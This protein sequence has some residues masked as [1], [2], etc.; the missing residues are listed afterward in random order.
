MNQPLRVLMV[1]DSEDDATLS[2]LT[3]RRGG[4]EVVYAAVDTPAA[5][6]DAL[7]HQDW[8]VITSDH[9]I[10]H[11]SAPAALALAKELCPDVPFIIVSGQ[12]D[13]NLAV[14]LIKEGAQDYIQ[15]RELPRLVPTIE[16]E[17]REAKMRREHQQAKDALEISE[18]RYR[19]L[20]ETAR[21]GI[22]ILDADSGQI[23][24]VNPF[25]I[26]MLG[27]SKEDL[28]GKKLWEIGAIRDKEASR[29]AFGELQSKGYVR[30]EDLPLETIAGQPVSVEFVS[31]IYF[32]NHT[33]V[34]Q[35]NIRDITDRKLAEE[36][37]EGLVIE[38]KKALSQIKTLSGF[39]PICASCKKIRNDKG[40][41]EQI[42]VYIR[43]H[44]EAE[45]SHSICP[46]C[47]EKLYPKHYKKIMNK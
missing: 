10:P 41:W 23:L 11:F 25:L 26:E 37:R 45:F 1:E 12:I 35:C 42:E 24:D 15:K 4:Y 27:Y 17:L 32:V 6:R 28:L 13:L 40:Y 3:L 34:A 16:R 20:F 9:A 31:N 46:V 33:K 19:R 7:E 43:D 36:E 5:M 47:A 29:I 30:Y 18:A 2:L 44:S 8:D 22:L 21:D 14:S 38:L 39:L